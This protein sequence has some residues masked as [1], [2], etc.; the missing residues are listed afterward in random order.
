[1]QR[2]SV[3]DTKALFFGDATVL[4]IGVEEN[5][6]TTRVSQD[7]TKLKPEPWDPQDC[8]R[9]SSGKSQTQH[10]GE[11]FA[12]EACEQNRPGNRKKNHRAKLIPAFQAMTVQA[13]CSN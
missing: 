7:F 13:H 4:W 2:V 5:D 12:G 3:N 10:I 1:M 9:I 11:G 6:R 8:D